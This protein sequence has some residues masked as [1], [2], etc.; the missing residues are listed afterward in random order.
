MHPPELLSVSMS[1]L[2]I[3]CKRCM[4]TEWLDHNGHFS[5]AKFNLHAVYSG[6]VIETGD[7][8]SAVS[9]VYTE[10]IGPIA[11]D[12]SWTSLG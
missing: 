9:S 6:N 1:T 8:W 3:Q 7:V 5:C 12:S 10:M 11:L 2:D 4:Y